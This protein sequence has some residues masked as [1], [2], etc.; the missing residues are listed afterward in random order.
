MASTFKKKNREIT[1]GYVDQLISHVTGME[2]DDENFE[3]AQN[4]IHNKLEN[5]SFPEPSEILIKR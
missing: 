4:F 3:I 2:N 5:H 1:S